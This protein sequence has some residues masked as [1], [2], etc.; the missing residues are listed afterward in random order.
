MLI[1]WHVTW[2]QMH[3]PMLILRK[4]QWNNTC[5]L[6]NY[7][8]ILLFLTFSSLFCNASTICSHSLIS[9]LWW[10]K[11]DRIKDGRGKR[12][13]GIRFASSLLRPT[14]QF[15][16]N[17]ASIP[18]SVQTNPSPLT[19]LWNLTHWRP[20]PGRLKTCT[21]YKDEVY[22]WNELSSLFLQLL[23]VLHDV[24][25]NAPVYSPFGEKQ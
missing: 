25:H 14:D 10:R 4:L 22:C 20:N 8:T 2:G 16:S 7:D 5:L 6:C 21:T 24:L 3:N 18:H 15:P 19:P 17:R 13:S 23:T 11:R 1:L 12:E 9:P